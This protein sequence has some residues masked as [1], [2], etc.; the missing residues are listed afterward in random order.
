MPK[1]QQSEYYRTEKFFCDVRLRE[2]D[3]H[4][5][6][7]TQNRHKIAAL[8]SRFVGVHEYRLLRAFDH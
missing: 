3:T 7:T 5:K 8:E 4:Y 6:I 2:H 1:K